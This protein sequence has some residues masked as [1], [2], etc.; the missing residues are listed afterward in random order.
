MAGALYLSDGRRQAPQL[1][2]LRSKIRKMREKKFLTPVADVKPTA[3]ATTTDTLL[4]RKVEVVRISQAYFKGISAQVKKE[5][6][7]FPKAQIIGAPCLRPIVKYAIDCTDA[8]LENYTYRDGLNRMCKEELFDLRA[9]APDPNSD[10][11]RAN[12]AYLYDWVAAVYGWVSL[13]FYCANIQPAFLFPE[14]KGVDATIGEGKYL[15]KR[16]GLPPT[17]RQ[18]MLNT[19]TMLQGNQAIGFGKDTNGFGGYWYG[20]MWAGYH[21][22]GEFSKAEC[23]AGKVA[24]FAGRFTMD[25]SQQSDGHEHKLHGSRQHFGAAGVLHRLKDTNPAVMSTERGLRSYFEYGAQH[26]GAVMDGTHWHKPARSWL[27][28]DTKVVSPWG[29]VEI[30]NAWLTDTFNESMMG[31]VG[32]SFGFYSSN[33]LKYFVSQ[34]MIDL[35]MEDIASMQSS[36]AAIRATAG[37]EDKLNIA[38]SAI[39]AV[40]SVV[41]AAVPIWGTLIGAI[42]AALAIATQ[43]IARAIFRKKKGDPKCPQPIGLRSLSDPRCDTLATDVTIPELAAM[44]QRFIAAETY[45]AQA[46]GPSVQS[47]MQA[48]GWAMPAKQ[49]SGGVTTQQLVIGGGVVIGLA[50][51]IRGRR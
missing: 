8:N 33:H 27:A 43:F 9:A 18:V 29:I 36:M 15:P 6:V 28:T 48:G 47:F 50:M 4:G 1:G 14:E 7:D 40:A 42:I 17:V 23:A 16:S 11:D 35:T 19:L 32:A 20:P 12:P 49:G 21:D 46:G 3:A 31:F 25:V 24:W 10:A 5:F 51:L 26:T 44:N 30:A 13:A 2:R 22:V 38:T 45:E 39:T 37:K 41:A 34:G